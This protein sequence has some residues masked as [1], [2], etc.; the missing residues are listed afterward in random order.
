MIELPETNVK[1]F[2]KVSRENYELC[3]SKHPNAF[4]TFVA[5]KDHG[6]EHTFNVWMKAIEIASRI[7]EETDKVCL[8]IMAICHDMGRFRLPTIDENHE[9]YQKQIKRQERSESYHARYGV[10]QIRKGWLSIK[11][12]IEVDIKW[13]IR[14]KKIKHYILNHDKMTW[15]L[16]PNDELPNS[17]E[18]QIVLLA[19]RISTD[20]SKE[21]ERYWETGKRRKTAFFKPEITLEDRINF[22]FSKI[23][24]YIKSGKLDQFMFFFAMLAISENDFDHLILKQIYKEWASQKYVDATETIY[25]LARE[26]GYDEIMISQMKNHIDNYLKH[27]GVEF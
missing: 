12:K 10:A 17:L 16:D 14:Y 21:I 19:D 2:E 1:S 6:L 23:G 13:E 8:Y 7:T 15:W 9:N 3:F 25:R 5:N 20:A 18:G 27:Y 24:E 4:D 11:N 26:N 22:N